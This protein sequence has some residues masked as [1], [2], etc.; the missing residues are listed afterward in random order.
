VSAPVSP[1]TSRRASGSS[2]TTHRFAGAVAVGIDDVVVLGVRADDDDPRFGD[3]LLLRLRPGHVDVVASLPWPARAISALPDGRFLVV[4]AVDSLYVV[5]GH[6]A[7]VLLRSGVRALHDGVILGHDGDVSRAIVARGAVFLLPRGHVDGARVLGSTTT[8]GTIL[9]GAVD[10][11]VVEL[12]EQGQE[13]W[14]AAP[15]DASSTGA[16][17]DAVAL[18]DGVIAIAAGRCLQVGP[19]RSVLPQPA[20]SVA[21][22]GSRWFVGTTS[23]GLFVVDDDEDRVAALRPSL[24]AHQLV[25]VDD[26]LVVVS[27]LFVATS[28]DG[29]DFFS[30]DLSAF[31]RLAAR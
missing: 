18:V 20:S 10:G 24:R 5:D 8:P 4:D 16:P 22:L 26:G 1:D 12:D 17:V 2:V 19:R 11:S 21:R 23:S 13:R 27:D 3:S 25:V 14:R 6:T 7:P 30:R 9:I 28:M 15:L 29:V 31:V